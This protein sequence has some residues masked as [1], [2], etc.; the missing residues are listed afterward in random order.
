MRF[1]SSRKWPIAS[2]SLFILVRLECTLHPCPTRQ[3]IITNCPLFLWLDF[4][5]PYILVQQGK[6]IQIVFLVGLECTPP[7][8]GW[9]SS[10]HPAMGASYYKNQ[11]KLRLSASPRLVVQI[12]L[13]ALY[14][15]WSQRSPVFLFKQNLSV[16]PVAPNFV[17]LN[18]TSG[19]SF[20]RV[21]CVFH[22]LATLKSLLLLTL[23]LAML[24]STYYMLPLGT[25]SH[26]RSRVF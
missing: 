11:V 16:V 14:L 23:I 15:S 20:T 24:S 2:Y 19:I 18:H 13:F 21:Q 10:F 6:K 4:I 9:W 7:S 12:S 17:L 8:P 1:K 25:S 22:Q 26:P 5:L 3:K